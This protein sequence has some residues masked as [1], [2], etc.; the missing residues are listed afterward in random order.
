[1]IFRCDI[2]QSGTKKCYY[3]ALPH[4]CIYDFGLKHLNQLH[5]RVINRETL[6]DFHNFE[7]EI[8]LYV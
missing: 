2:T 8:E 5:T 4:R 1:M 6:L 7:I 3:V